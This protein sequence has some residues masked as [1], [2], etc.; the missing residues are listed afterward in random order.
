MDFE[1]H[2]L[3]PRENYLELLRFGAM[4]GGLVQSTESKSLWRLQCPTVERGQSR[5]S[6][7]GL[8]ANTADVALKTQE[9]LG[10]HFAG[11]MSPT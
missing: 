10:R 3:K 4:G 9:H 8:S 2:N 6:K 1:K 5:A 7:K 11:D